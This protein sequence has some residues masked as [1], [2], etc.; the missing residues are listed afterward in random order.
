MPGLR[1]N[2]W[3]ASPGLPGVPPLSEVNLLDRNLP[4]ASI[5]VRLNYFAGLKPVPV[6]VVFDFRGNGLPTAASA[7][8]RYILTLDDRNEI[9][10]GGTAEPPIG[11]VNL[12]NRN[13]S[14]ASIDARLNHFAGLTPVPVGVVFNFRGNGLPTAASANA[15]YILTLYDRNEIQVGT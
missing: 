14:S 10:V 5:D 11:E 6:G 1:L 2:R 7:N 12:L 13:L 15:R 8:A 9:K 4:S 3:N